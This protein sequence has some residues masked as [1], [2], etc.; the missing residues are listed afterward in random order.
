M[1][2]NMKLS[3]HLATCTGLPRSLLVASRTSLLAL[4]RL[5]HPRRPCALWFRTRRTAVGDVT[6]EAYLSFA[7]ITV[8]HQMMLK[9]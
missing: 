5:Y 9:P 7:S 3:S 6:T 4:I 1:A 2:M 8:I